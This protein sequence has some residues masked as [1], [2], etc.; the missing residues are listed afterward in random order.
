MTIPLIFFAILFLCAGVFALWVAYL[1][2]RNSK[3]PRMAHDLQ[4]PRAKD[5]TTRYPFTY[6]EIKQC[7]D[8]VGDYETV[9]KLCALSA[10]L[11]IGYI[12]R[13]K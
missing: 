4:D 12:I 2:I 6:W 3:K 7:F 9:E 10:Q 11:G 8:E 5:L 13:I 1:A